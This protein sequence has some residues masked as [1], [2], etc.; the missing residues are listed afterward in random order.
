MGRRECEWVCA[1]CSTLFVVVLFV[2]VAGAQTATNDPSL[3]KQAYLSAL[4]IP[5]A[6]KF[7]EER[8]LEPVTVA[9]VDTGVDFAHPDLA[10]VLLP[11]I[12]VIDRSRPPQDDVGHGT[13]VAGVIAAVRDNREGISGIAPNAKIMPIKVVDK[14]G[15]GT[16]EQLSEG[17]R[18]AVDQGADVVVL[19]LGLHR[20]VPALQEV[21]EY[22]EQKN[23]VLIA[24]TGNTGNQV[25]YP[26]AYATVIAVGGVQ[27]SYRA[28]PLSNRGAE[29]DFVAP[30]T[31]YTTAI[32]NKYQYREG[33]SMAAPQVA[34][35]VA[36][37]L[38]QEGTMPVSVVRQRLRQAS[39]VNEQVGWNASTG[40]GIVRT[41]YLLQNGLRP[42]GYEP[43][44]N[45][46]LATP[47][48]I[49][50]DVLAQLTSVS[51]VDWYVVTASYA[52]ELAINVRS[53]AM[54]PIP[55]EITIDR[56]EEQPVVRQS[57]SGGEAMRVV[58]TK[59]TV[60]IGVRID[61]KV[62]LMSTTRIDYRFLTEFVIAP[63]A[64]EQNDGRE[65]AYVV[66]K[67]NASLIGTF[68]QVSD[69][70]WF[71]VRIVKPGIL[72]LRLTVDTPRIDG[73]MIVQS[74][75]V[76]RRYDDG[77]EGEAEYSEPIQVRAGDVYVRVRN[78]KT[79]FPLPV[80]GTYTLTI[81]YEQQ[82]LDPN[83]P[84]NDRTTA[85]P[86]VLDQ[87]RNGLFHTTKDEDWYS[88]R[89]Q[90][91]GVFLFRLQQIPRNRY[92]YVQLYAANG[93]LIESRRSTID[94]ASFTVKRELSVGNYS[95]RI[96]TDVAYQDRLYEFKIQR[97][98]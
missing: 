19:S 55:V 40:Y 3:G 71:I 78:V 65:K 21:V 29:I 89:A 77:G 75:D 64:Q 68:H 20:D 83:E 85:T 31:V 44:N 39:S 37:L 24:S 18:Y 35:I 62:K 88:F 97:E 30:W 82:I 92:M 10:G 47:I 11:G 59:Q 63:D 50:D 22:A 57:L 8:S 72:R 42:D 96:M 41:D 17:I 12:N 67:L 74:G 73:E 91:R 69:Q 34:G 54:F 43:N 5:E 76:D 14:N 9:I 95:I 53:R 38:G 84:N 25:T 52:G 46:R 90:K 45:P 1:V 36:L 60:R 80:L 6:W 86:I 33:T 16:E 61:P 48:S 32:G 66:P 2:S 70:D 13:N 98:P 51:D 93:R 49:S 94:E 23:V 28:H 4:R 27:E 87:S 79:R 7:V 15:I 81:Q 58:I 56:G 26:A